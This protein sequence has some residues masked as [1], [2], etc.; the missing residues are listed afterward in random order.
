M[1]TVTIEDAIQDILTRE[2]VDQYGFVDQ[3]H[4][5]EKAPPG[6]R[7]KDQLPSASSALVYIVPLRNHVVDNF[8]TT[9]SGKEYDAYVREKR[10]LS[11]HLHSIGQTLSDYFQT[12]GYDAMDVPKGSQKYMGSVSLKHLAVYAGLGFLGKNS[13]L[14]NPRYGPR[15]RIGAVITTYRPSAYGSCDEGERTCETCDRCIIACPSGALLVPRGPEKYCI[16]VETCH[17]YFCSMRGIAYTVEN[18]DVN[19]GFCMKACPAG[20]DNP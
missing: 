6:H 13:L 7:L 11:E 17:S 18:A 8:P 1:S 14:I 9:Y 12:M 3:S 19:C 16:S 15:L 2:G 5:D 4:Y 10:S 20:N